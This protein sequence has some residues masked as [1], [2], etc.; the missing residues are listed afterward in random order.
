MVF[1]NTQVIL[2]FF[3]SVFIGD[4]LWVWRAVC[5]II[6]AAGDSLREWRMSFVYQAAAEKI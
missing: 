2:E 6:A 3:F 5:I 4:S 1:S